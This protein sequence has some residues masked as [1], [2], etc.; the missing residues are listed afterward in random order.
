MWVKDVNMWK[1][2]IYIV[3]IEYHQFNTF[4]FHYFLPFYTIELFLVSFNEKKKNTK[5]NYNVQESNQIA[6]LMAITLIFIRKQRMFEYKYLGKYC[7][8]SDET[9]IASK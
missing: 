5:F 6:S 4:Y 8:T 3:S 2:V 9:D 7:D 1:E